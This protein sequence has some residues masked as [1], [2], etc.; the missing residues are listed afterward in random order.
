MKKM[1]LGFKLILGGIIAVLI[2]LTIV[3]IFASFKSSS[4]LEQIA[5]N[6]STEIAKGLANMTQLAVKEE[7]KIAT[8]LATNDTIVDVATKHAQNTA[9]S[10]DIEKAT[11]AL[12][13]LVKASGDE[14]EVIFVTGRDGKVFVDGVEGKYKG[15]DLSARDYVKEALAGKVNV[16]SVVKSKVSG[17][18]ILTFGAP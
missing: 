3:G 13:S 5:L 6:Q 18:P 14:Y 9:S 4:A 12:T 10:A 8:Q 15:I 7:L 1:T 16:G 17:L 2:P 11:A